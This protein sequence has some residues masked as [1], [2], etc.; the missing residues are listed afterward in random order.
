MTIEIDLWAHPSG[1]KHKKPKVPIDRDKI[2][3][4]HRDAA[5]A[6]S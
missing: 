6:R 2:R 5:T 4:K 1:T 3:R